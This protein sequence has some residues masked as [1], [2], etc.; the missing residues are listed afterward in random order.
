VGRWVWLFPGSMAVHVAE[1][2]LTGETFPRWISRVA[3][4]DLAFSE[5]LIL[6]AIAFGVIL[7]GT[8]LAL[9]LRSGGWPL[10]ALGTA[11]L[12]N[13]FFHVAGTLATGVR[14]PGVV[15]AVLLWLPLGAFALAS[16]AR[17]ARRSDLALGGAIG[18]AAHGLISLS[19]FL[20]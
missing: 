8:V 9:R 4:V 5:F 3:G 13:V 18:L 15:S 19:L 20:A 14:S 10:A 7:A 12:T 2:A 16:T 6:N 17:R 11:I 1:E